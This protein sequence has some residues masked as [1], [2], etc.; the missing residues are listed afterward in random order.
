MTALELLFRMSQRGVYFEHVGDKLRATG[1]TGRLTTDDKAVIRDNKFQILDFLKSA[2]RF[3]V[4]PIDSLYSPFIPGPSRHDELRLYA[5]AQKPEV[6]QWLYKQSAMYKG[7]Q[8]QWD[9][10][11]CEY[12]AM[13]DLMDWQA[14]RR[15]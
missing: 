4:I 5:T 2:P 3:N 15:G 13:Q 10:A 11:D 6:I 14:G 9:I 8:R 7:K 1:S 12:A